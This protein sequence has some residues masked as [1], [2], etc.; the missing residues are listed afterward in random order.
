MIRIIKAPPGM[1]IVG[2]CVA[3]RDQPTIM[4]FDTAEAARAWATEWAA[5]GVVAPVC[6]V[7]PATQA[8]I[9]FERHRQRNE[10][11]GLDW[12]HGLPEDLLDN[13]TT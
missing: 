8:L 1:P 6:H 2:W 3:S 4:G 9:N 10:S 11:I 12:K 13:E 7:G 5:R